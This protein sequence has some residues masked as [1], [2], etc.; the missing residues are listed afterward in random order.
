MT[1]LTNLKA[2]ELLEEQW[3]SVPGYEGLYNISN[4][5]KVLSMDRTRNC[6][7]KLKGR[8]VPISLVKNSYASFAVAD[9]DGN[10]KSLKIHK[11][12]AQLFIPNPEN[13][14]CINHKN[15]NKHDY[16]LSNLE[17]ATYS[18][19]SQHAIDTGLAVRYKGEKHSR[20]KLT[21]DQVYEI[22]DMHKSGMCYSEIASKYNLHKTNI[23][24]IVNGKSWTNIRR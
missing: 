23:G 5:G 10:P 22:L 24:K 3:L 2:G 17:W 6:G 18:E 13:K 15:G 1:T 21:E 20:A 11:V 19:N 7:L 8:E 14:K 12:L 16:S 9:L 4:L